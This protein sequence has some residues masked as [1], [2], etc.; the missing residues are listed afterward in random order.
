MRYAGCYQGDLRIRFDWISQDL[1]SVLKTSTSVLYL[2]L[3]FKI[4][5]LDI[6]K[7]VR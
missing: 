5:A 1:L 6:A 7:P 2:E 3:P 4:K